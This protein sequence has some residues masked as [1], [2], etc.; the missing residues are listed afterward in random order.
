MRYLLIVLLL[1][2]CSPHTSEITGEVYVFTK[3]RETVKLSGSTVY[4]YEGVAA[5][6]YL[7]N[8]TETDKWERL[9]G[10][11][12]PVFQTDADSNGQFKIAV[13]QGTYYLV[14][15]EDRATQTS[16][17]FYQWLVPVDA[18]KDVRVTLDN[19]NLMP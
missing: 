14:V 16:V 2:A 8:S 5:Q 19:S 4:V 11:P 13:P 9:K 18:S 3:G 15:V 1:V 7:S 10:L 6:N 17:E 12:K